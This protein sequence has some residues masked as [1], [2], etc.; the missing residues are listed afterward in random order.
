MPAI[1][2]TFTVKARP[3][4]ISPPN[5]D[6]EVVATF[7]G[8]L[9]KAAPP[10]A[11]EIPDLVESRIVPGLFFNFFQLS[12]TYESRVETP[13][14]TV[15]RLLIYLEYSA[16][17]AVPAEIRAAC[18]KEIGS[19][20]AFRSAIHEANEFLALLG[21]AKIVTREKDVVQWG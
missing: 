15:F 11:F 10:V 20:S 18:W 21:V 3:L 7:E 4:G 19:D 12:M 13:P 16:G 9:P 2:E 6:G 14:A 1:I 17:K 5:G 8:R